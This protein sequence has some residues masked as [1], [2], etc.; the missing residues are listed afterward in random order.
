MTPFSET[1]TLETCLVGMDV[2]PFSLGVCTWRGSSS[3]CP[4]ILPLFFVLLLFCRPL[5]QFALGWALIAQL[6][7]FGY[8]LCARRSIPADTFDPVWP[9]PCFVS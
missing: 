4:F 5:G 2:G 1:C 7:D 9:F 6:V 3:A 8:V